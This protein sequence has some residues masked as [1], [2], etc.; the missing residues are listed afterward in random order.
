MTHL[1]RCFLW[2]LAAWAFRR[3]WYRMTS[4]LCRTSGTPRR[5]RNTAAHRW[6]SARHTCSAVTWGFFPPQS[7]RV[8]GD[9]SQN[10]QSQRQVPQQPGV[11]TPLVV[12][13]PGFLF[14]ESERMLHGPTAEGDGQHPTQR[15][16]GG[17]GQEVLH[18]RRGL[19]D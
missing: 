11:V 1:C 15:R 3:W 18:L 8:G 7:L 17:V 2:D 6:F 5:R 12:H 10:H 14:A 16:M 9:E 4:L 13:Q 19:I